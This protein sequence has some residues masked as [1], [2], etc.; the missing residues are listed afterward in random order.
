MILIW[1][2]GDHVKIAKLTYGIIDPFILHASM[3]FSPYGNEVRQFKIPPTAF[4]E[5][6]PNI[7]FANISAYTVL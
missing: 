5:K 7:M 1:L 4:S 3:D 6:L 2:F